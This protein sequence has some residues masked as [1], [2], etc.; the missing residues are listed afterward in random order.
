MKIC[1]FHLPGQGARL[2][3]LVDQK[4]YNLTASGFPH[5]TSLTALR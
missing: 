1:R 5:F 4:I 3:Q 2:G